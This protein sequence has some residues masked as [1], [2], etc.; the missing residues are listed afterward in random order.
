MAARQLLAR[1]LLVH[2]QV[3]AIGSSEL[4][5][6]VGTQG[7]PPL[8]HQLMALVEVLVGEPEA[9]SMAIRIRLDSAIPLEAAKV[10]S[11]GNERCMPSTIRA[12]RKRKDATRAPSSPAA[13][14][15]LGNAHAQA[16][17]GGGR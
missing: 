3:A 17:G 5:L 8:R 4:V 6:I 14:E 13:I 1:A 10:H 2:A 9:G 11:F 12:Q 16:A 15:P 7:G